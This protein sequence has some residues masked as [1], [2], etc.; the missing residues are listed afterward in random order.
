MLLV[1]TAL[2]HAT[3]RRGLRRACMDSIQAL[4][5]ELSSAILF[6]VRFTRVTAR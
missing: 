6:Y 1:L 4:L 5:Y 2:S 3:H